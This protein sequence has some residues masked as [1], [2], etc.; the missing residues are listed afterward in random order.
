MV[1]TQPMT[2]TSNTVLTA[3]QMNTHLRDNL[4]ETEV[5]QAR[6]SGDFFIATGTN[7]VTTRTPKSAVVTTNL[8]STTS[9]EYTDLETVGPSVTCQTGTGCIVFISAFVA[10]STALRASRMGYQV[11]GAT[12]RDAS[13]HTAVHV[14]GLSATKGLRMTQLDLI[15]LSLVPGENTFTCKYRSSLDTNTASFNRR[16]II[17]IPL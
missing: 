3:A 11:S 1:W 9:T 4:L 6:A 14:D 7:A 13:D 2:F 17:V 12:E 15:R 10:S 5:A 8:E 16:S